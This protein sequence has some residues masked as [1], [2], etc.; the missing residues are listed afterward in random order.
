MKPT[1]IHIRAISQK[2]PQPSISK[3]CSTVTCLKYHSN[4]PGANATYQCA[5]LWYILVIWHAHCT[6]VHISVVLLVLLDPITHPSPNKMAA[7]SQTMCS[8]AFLWMKFF[9]FDEHLIEVLSKGSNEY[10]CYDLAPTQPQVTHCLNQWWVDHWRIYASLGLT[11]LRIN[12]VSLL[13][14]CMP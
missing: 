12:N 1:V 6:I 8:D 14:L 7:V 2:M 3:I 10:Y 4:F 13:A 5:L 11:E 9:L